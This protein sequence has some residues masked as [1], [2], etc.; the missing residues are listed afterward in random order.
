SVIDADRGDLVLV[1][2]PSLYV[3]GALVAL[4]RRHAHIEQRFGGLYRRLLEEDGIHAGPP[5][6]SDPDREGGR[7]RD[8]VLGVGFA[9]YSHLDSEYREVQR[10]NRANS[11][12]PIGCWE[13]LTNDQYAFVSLNIR[14][15]VTAMIFKSSASDH[16]RRYSRSHSTRALICSTV[17]VSPR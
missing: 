10:A 1:G 12:S 4:V 13:W 6:T 15:I 2:I 8:V 14:T 5:L 9:R 11:H 7:L 3:I 17:L 16:R